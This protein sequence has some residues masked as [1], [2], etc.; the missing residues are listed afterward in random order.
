MLTDSFG[1]PHN[2][3]RVSLT[4]SCNFRCTYCMPDETHSFA[5]G[6][7][8]MSAP[9]IEQM[10]RVFVNAG[11]TKVRL[12][13]G[14][15]LV[16]TDV[17]DILSRLAQVPVGLTLTT[18]GLLLHKYLPALWQAGMRSINVSLDTLRP[19]VFLKLTKRN[20]FAQVWNNIM[21]A[22]E[23]GLHVKLN[24]VAMKGFIETEVSDFVNLT[25]D[26][27]LHVRFIE[28]MPFTGNKWDS[29]Q[30]VTARQLLESVRQSF[31]VI[32]LSDQ[33]HA[34]AKAYTV[35]GHKG[36]FAFIT[37]M[38][39]QFCGDCNRL[40]LTAEGK[41]KNCLF[42]KEELDL[43]SALRNN[44]N[45]LELIQQSIKRKHAFMGGQGVKDYSQI[46]AEA[47]INRSMVSIGG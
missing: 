27:P 18:N 40:R 41:I 1:R 36:T 43:L 29:A 25:K 21:Q 35:I 4:E 13:G 28:F 8:Q 17:D 14:E 32:K 19:E 42:G 33:A 23:C 39:E 34:T 12:T 45:V 16:R 9:E 37:T 20:V 3:L 6:K 10:V 30:V 7:N 15:P 11:V 26:L 46:E 44:K 24:V 47:I 22:L 38:S 2:Y 31:D 5:P